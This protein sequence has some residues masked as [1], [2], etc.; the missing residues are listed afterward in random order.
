VFDEPFALRVERLELM[1]VQAAARAR[2][3]DVEEICDRSQEVTLLLALRC[4]RPASPPEW[5]VVVIV[6]EPGSEQRDAL[7]DPSEQDLGVESGR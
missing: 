5:F 4:G 2:A 1:T 6:R 7:V 3:F